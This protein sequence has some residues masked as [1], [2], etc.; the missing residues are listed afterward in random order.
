LPDGGYARPDWARMDES[1]KE[2]PPPP[3]KE[4][5]PP[6]PEPAA[7]GVVKDNPY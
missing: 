7:S 4:P 1:P 3:K 6:P 2:P 5:P